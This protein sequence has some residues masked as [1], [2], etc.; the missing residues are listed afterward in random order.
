MVIARDGGGGWAKWVKGVK[1][2]KLPVISSRDVKNSMVTAVIN[3][4]L[5]I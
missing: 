2:Y 3:T 4:V 1:G 5:H